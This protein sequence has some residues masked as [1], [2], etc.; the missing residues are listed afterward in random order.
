MHHERDIDHPID[1]LHFAQ[2]PQCL[3]TVNW[4]DLVVASHT[5]SQVIAPP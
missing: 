1:L 4:K 5:L 3:N 2:P